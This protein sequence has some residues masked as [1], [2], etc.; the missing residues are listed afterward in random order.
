M[1]V[2]VGAVAR[3]YALGMCCVCIWACA[4]HV[5]C[6]RVRACACMR[7]HLHTGMLW[8][9]AVCA[10]LYICTGTYTGCVLCVHM[11][12]FALEHVQG[13]RCVCLSSRLFLATML[14]QG[15]LSPDFPSHEGTF[16]EG[17]VEWEVGCFCSQHFGGGDVHVVSLSD[18]S[19]GYLSNYT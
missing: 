18:T 13:V 15:L 11:C 17:P 9:C 4:G 16:L 19:W 12:A 7:R 2:H 14:G 3:G 10:R 5:P 1:C 6:V 8:V